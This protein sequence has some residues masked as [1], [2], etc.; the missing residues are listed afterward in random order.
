MIVL[1]DGF[2][3][4]DVESDVMLPPEPVEEAVKFWQCE[5]CTFAENVW[6]SS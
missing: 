3:T 6:D 5:V 4:L 1:I 2:S